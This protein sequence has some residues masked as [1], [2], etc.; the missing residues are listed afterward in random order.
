M[1]HDT[2]KLIDAIDLVIRSVVLPD[3]SLRQE[4]LHIGCY[5]HFLEVREDMLSVLHGMRQE[6][7]DLN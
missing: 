1:N 4:A 7:I 6:A 2:S 5:D 3:E